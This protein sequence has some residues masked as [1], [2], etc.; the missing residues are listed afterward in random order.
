MPLRLNGQGE[1]IAT[2][3]FGAV[4][5]KTFHDPHTACVVKNDRA[6]LMVEETSIS[7]TVRPKWMTLA[8]CNCA[9]GPSEVVFF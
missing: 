6:S 5:T 3:K 4:S 8:N 1:W 9:D 7:H 2:C